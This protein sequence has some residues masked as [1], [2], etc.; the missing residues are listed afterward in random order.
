MKQPRLIDKGRRRLFARLV[1][2][3]LG[4]AGAAMAVAFLVRTV[5]GRLGT[6]SAD[7]APT[8]TSTSILWIMAVL[9]GVVGLTALFRIVERQDAERLG[10]NYVTQVRLRLF[11]ALTLVPVLTRK[12]R[13]LGPTL[14]RFVTDLTAV[15]QWIANGVARLVV[16][17]I[18]ITGGLAAFFV[19]D[20]A[21][22]LWITAIALVAVCVGATLAKHLE[23]RVRVAR[24]ARGRLA[25]QAGDRLRSLAV[26]QLSG[27]RRRERRTM[28]RNS[29][30]LAEALV[31]RAGVAGIVRIIPDAALGFSTVAILAIGSSRMLSGEA[32]PGMVIA[33]LSVL[34]AVASQA[35]ALGRVFEYWKSYQV[36]TEKLSEV[37]SDSARPRQRKFVKVPKRLEGRL[38]LEGVSVADTLKDVT[39]TVE[40]GSVI[41]L[42]GPSGA[43]K[44]LLLAA[45]A[46]LARVEHG[47][48]L[49]GGKN[50]ARI[51]GEAYARLVG[52]A[53]LDLPLVKGS[54][55]RNLVY[56]RGAA[57][58]REIADVCRLCGIDDD[59]GKLD[60]MLN[61]RVTEESFD[62]PLGLRQRLS[63]ARAVI[64]N[65]VLLLLDNPE[66]GLDAEGHAALGRVLASRRFT[67]LFAS[68][69]LE[70]IRRADGIWYVE[71]GHVFDAG[72]PRTAL[73]SDGPLA[74]YLGVKA[75]AMTAPLPSGVQRLRKE[76]IR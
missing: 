19:I 2:N 70:W 40:P 73:K 25:S 45:I 47:R 20:P 12:R 17:S 16:A 46:R 30:R 51:D 58:S 56:Q 71:N 44:S 52:M 64:G 13:G 18:A 28:S 1:A 55:R 59:G 27:Q 14:L 67:I 60:D 39:A 76:T 32:D 35:R 23:T 6:S 49:L 10:Q 33:A 72:S 41:A 29:G 54:I 42:I 26:M 5:F 31:A 48:V 43:G 8:S 11:D 75:G 9:V 50:I 21:I 57:S 37:L 38:T 22:G 61:T 62:L 74:R 24:R 3:G 15:R 63:L 7:T 53:S 34:G 69:D 65:P 36:A 66:A 4:Q 68:H